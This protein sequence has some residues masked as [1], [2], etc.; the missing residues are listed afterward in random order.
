MRLRLYLLALCALLCMP[1]ATSATAAEKAKKTER[2][3]VRIFRPVA[4]AAPK[5][6]F[7]KKRSAS[8]MGTSTAA[9]PSIGE[10]IGRQG[11]VMGSQM[12]GAALGTLAG[13]PVGALIGGWFGCTFSVY[14]LIQN[15]FAKAERWD[16]HPELASANFGHSLIGCSVF[17][18]IQ[19]AQE[20][21]NGRERAFALVQG[22]AL[23]PNPYVSLV[24]Q[25]APAANAL[26]PQS[27]AVIRNGK[28]LGLWT[29][30]KPYHNGEPWEANTPG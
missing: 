8:V 22:L 17:G 21:P 29:P 4:L 15:D 30:S 18:F 2:A 10:Q 9:S 20:A 27:G 12:G 3:Q 7:K 24:G 28:F 6:I 1:C 11:L 25:L 5:K 19:R 16:L 26:V 13:G 23:V 14:G